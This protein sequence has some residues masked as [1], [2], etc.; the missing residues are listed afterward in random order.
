[1][2]SESQ[3][4][5]GCHKFLSSQDYSDMKF[6]VMPHISPDST[7]GS[8]DG[9]SCGVYGEDDT[10]G[11]PGREEGVVIAAHRVIVAARCEYFK[12]ALQSGMKEAIDRYVLCV[13]IHIAHTDS[14]VFPKICVHTK[15]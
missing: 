5:Q 10:E 2:A 8:L 1:M 4:A 13:S 11:M 7:P 15:V 6:V 14:R 12:R 3:L 9:L